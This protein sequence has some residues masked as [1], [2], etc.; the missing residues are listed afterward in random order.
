MSG[1]IGDF[2]FG[3]LLG[4]LHEVL[5]NPY[6]AS[7][8]YSGDGAGNVDDPDNPGQIFVNDGKGGIGRVYKG[9]GMNNIP[10]GV[11]LMLRDSA[12]QGWA[13]GAP[14]ATAVNFHEISGWQGEL[15]GTHWYGAKRVLF[16]D[17]TTGNATAT[18]N[19]TFDDAN[20]DL[21]ITN[22]TDFALIGL[23]SYG[24]KR[25]AFA[26]YTAGGTKSSPTQT[27]SGKELIR[28]SITG[29]GTT[30]FLANSSAR[31]SAWSTEQ[32]SD[33]A[34]GSE[35]RIY[36]TP[37]T[38]NTPTLAAV[39]QDDQRAKLAAGLI[40]KRRGVADTDTTITAADYLVGY[41]SLS[42][43]RV[44]NLTAAATLGTGSEFY[45][46]D[47]SG[48]CNGT[49]TL[50]ITPAAGTID[51]AA[52]LVLNTAY[53]KCHIYTDGSNWYTL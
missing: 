3:L 32:F 31:L 50:T 11:P 41:S 27:T 20:G 45:V 14:M 4:D 2:E 21:E 52:T 7:T 15:Y 16:G 6:P 53:A 40:V 5:T 23:N 25:A 37:K 28:L 49:K 33:T 48:S 39:F 19:L 46:K 43:A 51:G 29:Y 13:A 36:T 24:D 10:D 9:P 26:G 30:G 38:T 17:A 42:A 44:V 47:E 22:P 8:M 34:S 12:S 35:W 1:T 18:D